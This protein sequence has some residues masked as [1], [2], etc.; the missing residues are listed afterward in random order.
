MQVSVDAARRP[1]PPCL[2]HTTGPVLLM[3]SAPVSKAH[4]GLAFLPL[5][6][7]TERPLWTIVSLFLPLPSFPW[8]CLDLPHF[9]SPDLLSSV[10]LGVIILAMPLLQP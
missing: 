2:L 10:D 6:S 4:V 1:L 7:C 8:L 5:N 3:V 9:G